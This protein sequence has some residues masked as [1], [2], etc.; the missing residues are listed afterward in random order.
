MSI[1]RKMAAATA[2]SVGLVALSS[3]ASA[4]IVCNEE[5]DCWHAPDGFVIAPGLGLTLHPDTWNWGDDHRYHWREHPGRGYWR[6]HE[7]HEVD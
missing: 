4:R 7:W 1:Y 5:G 6:R 2:V 3:A